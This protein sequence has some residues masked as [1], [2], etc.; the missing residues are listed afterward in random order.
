M[1]NYFRFYQHNTNGCWHTQED[2]QLSYVYIRVAPTLWHVIT[3]YD[4]IWSLV[5]LISFDLIVFFGEFHVIVFCWWNGI[6]KEFLFI[7][8]TFLKTIQPTFKE[9]MVQQNQILWK[10]CFD[11]FV[12]QSI[13]FY[14]IIEMLFIQ[15]VIK[16][17]NLKKKCI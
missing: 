14:K 11:F 12:A 8:W 15:I 7:L 2:K 10:I 1:E 17:Q 9:I 6:D 4:C 13:T 16:V 3:I 5:N